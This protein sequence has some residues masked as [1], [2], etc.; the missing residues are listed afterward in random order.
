MEIKQFL[1]CFVMSRCQVVHEGLGHLFFLNSLSSFFFGGG[2]LLSEA[3][4]ILAEDVNGFLHN[5]FYFSVS[6]PQDPLQLQM[7][8][9]YHHIIVRMSSTLEEY[10][11]C[12]L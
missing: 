12:V 4:L 5:N 7:L 10:E 1:S 2:R 9:S 3:S 8:Y 6:L 11:V